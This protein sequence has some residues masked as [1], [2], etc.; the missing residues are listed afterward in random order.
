MHSNTQD[1]QNLQMHSKAEPASEDA[2]ID[3]DGERDLERNQKPQEKAKKREPEEGS[4]HQ[5]QQQKK[6]GV[7]PLAKDNNNDDS[8]ELQ[9]DHLSITSEDEIEEDFGDLSSLQED[10][11]QMTHCI[12]KRI[13]RYL[14]SQ[15]YQQTSNK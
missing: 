1:D 9:Q 15:L 13:S 5:Q 8:A 4:D 6:N 7:L 12:R 3:D 10:P 11:G 14:D 2:N